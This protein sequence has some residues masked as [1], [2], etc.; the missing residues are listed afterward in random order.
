[1]APLKFSSS[2]CGSYGVGDCEI[3]HYSFNPEVLVKSSG[4][5]FEQN[6]LS[7]LLH[8]TRHNNEKIIIIIKNNNNLAPVP[9]FTM[10][11]KGVC[12]RA[13]LSAK[14]ALKNK[15]LLNKK[16]EED[17]MIINC[18]QLKYVICKYF[19]LLQISSEISSAENEIHFSHMGNQ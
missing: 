3:D 11:I 16:E 18:Q 17:I 10:L 15:Q 12:H 7:A 5:C 8:L 9:D 14:I 19:C 1:M 4:L 13:E 6:I 2:Y